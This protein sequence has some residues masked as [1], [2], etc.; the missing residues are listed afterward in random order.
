[1]N[2]RDLIRLALMLIV[3]GLNALLSHYAFQGSEGS[4]ILSAV[5]MASYAIIAMAMIL[6]VQACV[7]G[8]RAQQPKHPRL[9]IENVMVHVYG[10]GLIIFVTVYCLMG[11]SGDASAA[12][13]VMVTAVGLDDM[14]VR[15]KDATLR[16][17]LLFFCALLAGVSNILSALTARDAGETIGAIADQQ[18]FTVSYGLILPCSVPFVLFSLRGKR[19]YTPVTIYDFLHFGMPFALILATTALV[20]L[21]LSAQKSPSSKPGA[22]PVANSTDEGRLVTSADVAGPLLCLNMLPTVFLAIQSALLYSTVDLLAVT[23]VVASFKA[24]AE[25]EPGTLLIC[26]FVA[27]SVAFSLRVYACYR[28]Q[29]DKCSVAYTK[30]S[31]EDEEE[32][33]MLEKLRT[34]LE[35]IANV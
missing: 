17:S 23:A 22:Q 3:L 14:F 33:Q 32:E 12:Y 4:P 16:R 35:E 31:E 28:D 10:L 25:R 27:S 7:C 19:F 30:E 26:G 15:T 13:F 11:V 6:V 29:D 34:D 24:L 8:K 1:M 20:A 21:S 9:S 5:A 18:W 2:Q